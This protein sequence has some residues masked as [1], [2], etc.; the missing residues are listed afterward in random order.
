MPVEVVAIALAAQEEN[1]EAKAGIDV[2]PSRD[3]WDFRVAPAR[4]AHARLA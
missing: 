3:R 2:P 1:L 4:P